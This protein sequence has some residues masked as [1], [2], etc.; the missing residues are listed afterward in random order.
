MAE[1]QLPK[2]NTRVRFPSSAPEKR[3]SE[4][5]P[6]SPFSL[7]QIMA[8]RIEPLPR[9]CRGSKVPPRCASRF[10]RSRAG[11]GFDSCGSHVTACCRVL[12]CGTAA[13]PIRRLPPPPS[14]SLTRGG[15]DFYKRLRG[16]RPRTPGRI[17]LS[18]GRRPRAPV[19]QISISGLCPHPAAGAATFPLAHARGKGFL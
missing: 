4:A 8:P 11:P 3:E 7:E 6:R 9:L 19:D 1:H 5:V 14:P 17:N 15:K 13:T 2:L 16:L 12:S 18:F 10:G